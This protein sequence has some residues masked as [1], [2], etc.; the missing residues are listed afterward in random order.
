[1]ADI[2]MGS[3][4]SICSTQTWNDYFSV[5]VNLSWSL[6]LGNRTGSL[7]RQG[8]LSLRAL[9][10]NRS[11]VG[12]SL[13]REAR[14]SLQQLLLAYD[15]SY[16]AQQRYRIASDNFRLA[17]DKH[18]A[19]ALSSNRLLEIE[20]SLNEAEASR[21]ATRADYFV[22]RAQYLYATGSDNLG[23]GISE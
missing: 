1:M 2:P 11:S 6:N 9:E 20:A 10:S 21:A 5:G 23:K 7:V 18:R 14:L 15:R 19:G 3:L 12:E 17:R 13:D 16:T 22:S 4:I 8:R